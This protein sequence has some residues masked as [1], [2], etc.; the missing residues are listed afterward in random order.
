MG[1]ALI[2]NIGVGVGI[3]FG[4]GLRHPTNDRGVTRRGRR[5][6]GMVNTSIM[7]S[8]PT[9][10]CGSRLAPLADENFSR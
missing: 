10:G 6:S 8:A 5:R 3:C 9:P 1:A 2:G 7:A 4:E